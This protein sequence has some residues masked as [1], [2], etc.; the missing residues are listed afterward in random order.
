MAEHS[1]GKKQPQVQANKSRKTWIR[2]SNAVTTSNA[3]TNFIRRGQLR[4]HIKHVL[5]NTLLRN[6][7][8]HDENLKTQAGSA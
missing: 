5:D 2:H 6:L 4:E 3:S 8:S 7:G 1:S